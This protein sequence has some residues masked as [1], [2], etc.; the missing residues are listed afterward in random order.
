MQDEVQMRG[1]ELRSATQWSG[2]WKAPKWQAQRFRW[3][4]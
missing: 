2:A 1:E 4:W 3:W